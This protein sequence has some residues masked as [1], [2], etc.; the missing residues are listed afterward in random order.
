MYQLKHEETGK[1]EVVHEDRMKLTYDSQLS[2]RQGPDQARATNDAQQ[3]R[4]Q[5]RAR[6]GGRKNT[7]NRTNDNELENIDASSTDDDD[8][9]TY[10]AVRNEQN[11]GLADN[12]DDYNPVV[13]VRKE[14]EAGLADDDGDY[15]S[16]VAGDEQSGEDPARGA[17]TDPEEGGPVLDSS[18]DKEEAG[19]AA[20]DDHGLGQPSTNEENVVEA[21]G[22]NE[23]AVSQRQEFEAVTG[24]GPAAPSAEWWKTLRAPSGTT[25]R[26]TPPTEAVN[27]KNRAEQQ[28]VKGSAW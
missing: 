20:T 19:G 18:E 24:E 25:P 6:K 10:V 3:D 26:K 22:R 2:H 4:Y 5:L 15:N 11:A 13:A 12:D 14:Q 21:D 27:T 8:E 16:V 23:G 17:D 7:K 9:Y 1:T 28:E